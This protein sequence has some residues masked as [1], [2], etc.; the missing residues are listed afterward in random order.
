MRKYAKK[1]PLSLNKVL[2]LIGKPAYLLFTIFIIT[3]AAILRLCTLFVHRHFDKLRTLRLPSL[4]RPTPLKLSLSRST[5]P[6]LHLPRHNWKYAYTLLFFFSIGILVYWYILRELPSVEL[7]TNNP[8]SLT[9]KIYDREGTLLYQIYKDENRTLI[10]LSDLPRHVIDATLAAEDKSFYHHFGVDP[11]GILR[12]MYNNFANCKLGLAICSPQGGSTIT[13]QLAKNA[14]LSPEKSWTR[15]LKE[16]VLALSIERRYTKDQILEMYLN[17]VGYGGTAYGIEQASRQY[18]GKS[19]IDLSL[20]EASLLAGLPVSPTT[21][22]PFGT[23]PYLGKIRQQQVLAS[24]VQTGTISEDEKIGV[25]ATPLVFNPQGITIRAPHFVM[26]I[27][28]L[29]VKNFGEDVVARGGLE[30]VTTL[31]LNYQEILQQEIISELRRLEKLHV[32]NAAGLVIDPLSGEIL[33]MVGSHDFFDSQHDGQVN[34]TLQERQPGSTIKPITYALAFSRGMTPNTTIDDSP[35]CFVLKGQPDYC[36]K[37]YDGRFHGTVTLR[38]ALA[39]SYNIPAIKLLNSFGVTSLVN[40]GKSLGITTWNDPSR[41]GLSLTLGGGEV[42]M[43]DMVQVYSVFA[44]GGRKVPLN[45]II[46]VKD[47]TGRSLSIGTPATSTEVISPAIAYQ[48]NSILSDPSARAPAFGYN[49][50]LN[51]P[52][53]N[54]AVKTGTTN[55]LRDNWTFGYTQDVLVAAWVGNNDNSPMSSVASGI[56]GAS[57]IWARTMQKI[58]AGR[59]PPPFTPPSN[60]VR[61]NISCSDKPRYEYFVPGTAPR[62]DCASPPPG[63]LLDSSATTSQ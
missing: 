62:I 43:L 40:L 59:I 29:L 9:T 15:K 50:I 63:T 24:M 55:A 6:K 16:F 27:K 37:N 33:A 35:V 56:T 61:V 49:S 57:P 17:Q 44:T 21:L 14:L 52:G 11:Q 5:L 46:S 42:T 54:V 1:S 25:L 45:P 12:A 19:A 20:A 10:N 53:K 22:S 38:T 39:S 34:V 4:S 30:V 48:I 47:A 41:F 18:F 51:L 8:P 13:Q 2:E 23:N 3:F 60:M 28:D 31:N 32:Q 36:P 7:L 26:Y 58:L